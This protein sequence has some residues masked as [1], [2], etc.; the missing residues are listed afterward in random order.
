MGDMQVTT[1][2]FWAD[3]HLHDNFP[4]G[5]GRA[6]VIKRNRTIAAGRCKQI[7]LSWVEPH[8]SDSLRAPGKAADRL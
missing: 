8:T 5:G 3:V 1:V 2:I 6:Q 4:D 7:R